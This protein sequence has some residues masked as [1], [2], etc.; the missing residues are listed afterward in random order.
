MM[1]VDPSARRSF[2]IKP[3]RA[4]A[5]PVGGRS[6]H[7]CS[8][9]RSVGTTRPHSRASIASSARSFAPCTRSGMP[10]SPS[11]SID[12][13][14]R[15]SMKVT[16]P[17][18]S[19]DSERSARGRIVSTCHAG[20]DNATNFCNCAAPA[21]S[22][23]PSTWRS[24]T[25]PTSVETTSS[26]RCLPTPSNTRPRPAALS[27]AGSPSCASRSAARTEG[28]GLQVGGETRKPRRFEPV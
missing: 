16:V 18:Q 15:I 11:T 8:I 19:R 25:S 7:R 28:F 6:C 24:N 5:T 2:E 17:I 3:C 22:S 27:A 10:S 26:C 20:N 23:A 13:R 1:S 12:P 21:P 14:R 9:R 4:F